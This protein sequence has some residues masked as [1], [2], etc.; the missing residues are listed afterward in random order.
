MSSARFGRIQKWNGTAWAVQT[1]GTTN[2]LNGVCEAAA[3]NIW[4][5]GNS[6]TILH[7][8]Q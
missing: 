3:N 1:S 8:T 7:K 2:T 4:I 6:G 5:V